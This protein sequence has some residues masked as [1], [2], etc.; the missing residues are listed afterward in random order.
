MAMAPGGK[1]INPLIDPGPG[2]DQKSVFDTGRKTKSTQSSEVVIIPDDKPKSNSPNETS[3]KT[4]KEPWTFVTAAK[5]LVE[6]IEG[7]KPQDAMAKIHAFISANYDKIS[8]LKEFLDLLK[9]D[10]LS[11]AIRSSVISYSLQ[12]L[13]RCFSFEAK[14]KKLL[15]EEEQRYTNK[16]AELK[17][18]MQQDSKDMGGR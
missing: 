16:V 15:K 5:G 12:T 4:S 9:E 17:H 7:M 8:N 6:E 1:T 3:D 11:A 13:I 10:G 18:D 2:G 14:L